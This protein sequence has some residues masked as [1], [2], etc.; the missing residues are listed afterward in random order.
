MAQTLGLEGRGLSNIQA[1]NLIVDGVKAYCP[2]KL[3]AGFP[4]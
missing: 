2:E 4:G 1:S 3:P